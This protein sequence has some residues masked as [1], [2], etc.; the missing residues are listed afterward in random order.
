MSSLS[1]DDFIKF[2]SRLLIRILLLCVLQ[3]PSKVCGTT[4]AV[5]WSMTTYTNVPGVAV[6]TNVGRICFG[7]CPAVIRK[8]GSVVILNYGGGYAIWNTNM[9]AIDVEEGGV[10]ELLPTH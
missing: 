2:C 10:S 6:A 1:N 4:Q 5:G 3:N 7:Y 9:L 8:D